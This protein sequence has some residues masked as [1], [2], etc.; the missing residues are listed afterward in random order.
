MDLFKACLGSVFIALRF[1]MNYFMDLFVLVNRF[2]MFGS[3]F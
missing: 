3:M 2:M 1:V